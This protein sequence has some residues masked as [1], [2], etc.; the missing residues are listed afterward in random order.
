[1]RVAA[2]RLDQG[3]VV[4]KAQLRVLP[5][6]AL[7][8]AGAAERVLV[9]VRWNVVVLLQQLNLK[10]RVLDNRSQ[11]RGKRERQDRQTRLV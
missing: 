7:E 6:W 2:E 8:P 9:S 3:H 5:R 11:V 1:M 10:I 4:G